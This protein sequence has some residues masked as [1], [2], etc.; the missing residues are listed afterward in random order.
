MT[1]D[2]TEDVEEVKKDK[3]K[4]KEPRIDPSLKL[5]TPVEE[6]AIPIDDP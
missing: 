4:V 2:K 1:R 3:K 5:Q 6:V